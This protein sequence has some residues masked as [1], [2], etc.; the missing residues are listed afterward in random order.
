MK[1]TW[2]GANANNF[3]VGRRGNKIQ[4]IVMHWIVGKLS[5]ADA[6][7]QDP[8]RIASAHYGVGPNAVHQ[9]V[10]DED[11]AYHAGNLTVN[12][13]SIG[14]EHEGGPNLPITEA[15]YKNSIELVTELV[16][17]YNIPLDR[18]HI[19]MHREISATQCPGTLDVDRV[20]REVSERIKGGDS[21]NPEIIKNSDNWIALLQRYK[22]P[23][24]KDLVF[25]EVDKVPT[26]EDAI[27]E[28][29]R[30]IDTLNKQSVD[31]QNKVKFLQGELDRVNTENED[32]KTLNQKLTKET[33]K[34]VVTVKEQA[35]DLEDRQLELSTLSSKIKELEAEKPVNQMTK[36]ELIWY[37]FNRLVNE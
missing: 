24:N 15:V 36:K 4:K 14:I 26:Y 35:Q 2:K 29:D 33:E 23:N 8:K 11:T 18:V 7:F 1:I 25:A 17:K 10:K 32:Q 37:T 27:R 34:L 19:K 30:T 13:Q 12:R 28:K 22:F 9:Y 6:T 3:E 21:V 16:K 20:I 5:A 31:F